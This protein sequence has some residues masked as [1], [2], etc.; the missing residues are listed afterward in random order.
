M[1]KHQT[2]KD[3]EQL[4]DLLNNLGYR[5]VDCGTSWRTKAVFRGGKNPASIQIYK[6]SGVWIDFANGGQGRPLEALIKSTLQDD[7][8]KCRTVLKKLGDPNSNIEVEYI[9]PQSKLITM[10]KIYDKSSLGDLFPNYHFYNK[11]GIS[12]KVQKTYK[13][14]VSSS[15]KLYR[16]VV[17]PIYN[18]HEQIMGFSGRH[19]SNDHPIKWKHTGRKTQWV[20]P[21]YTP[22]EKTVD[23]II[24]E[25]KTVFL[26]ESIGDSLAMAEQGIPNNLVTFGLSISPALLSYLTSKEL[27]HICL[28][29]NNDTNNPKGNL[30]VIS[31]VKNWLKLTKY[32]NLNQLFIKF[33]PNNANDLSQ[34]HEDGCNFSKLANI[35]SSQ[36]K[37]Q[38]SGLAKFI[39]ENKSSFKREEALINKILP[40][41]NE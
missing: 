23:E 4:K 36:I 26:V 11:K 30:G 24:T 17:F 35:C 25:T 40:L 31:A 10:E 41:L 19:L 34:A 29:P 20:Y 37:P 38:R 1:T 7:P 8:D 14:G 2:L 32:F 6:N 12:D 13:L 28:I 39:R 15:G 27:E 9:S 18:E 5:L 21:A 3:S 22:A 33:P 16:R